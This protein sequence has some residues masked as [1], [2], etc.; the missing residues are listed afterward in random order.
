LPLSVP[1]SR[2]TPRVGGGSFSLG[3]LTTMK[4][5]TL[6]ILSAA[7]LVQFILVACLLVT[8]FRSEFQ[9]NRFETDFYRYSHQPATAPA[10]L[11]DS[12][13]TS[14]DSASHYASSTLFIGYLL[15]VFCIGEFF[16]VRYF[17]RL[18]TS[19]RKVAD[20]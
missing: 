3:I 13:L 4:T 9:Q 19:D 20:A 11:A 18:T 10:N 2:F 8:S 15:V 17:G 16:L 7:I 1:L 6:K 14:S 5:K 12:A